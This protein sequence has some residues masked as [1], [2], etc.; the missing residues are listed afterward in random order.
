MI[1]L[2]WLRWW[3]HRRWIRF[4]IRDRL[5]RL[6][7][8]PEA[9]RK[10]TFS[11]DFFGYRYSGDLGS[12]VDWT[13]YFYGAY[14]LVVLELL[15]KAAA[16]AGPGAVYFDVGA[17]VGQHTLY[18]ANHV[19]RIHAFEPW[20]QVRDRLTGLVMENHLNQVTVHHFAL[21]DVEA[22]LPFF[23]P[24]TVNLGTG[25][26][27][28]G[29]NINRAGGEFLVRVGDEVVEEL[30][31]NRLDLV[32]IDTEGFEERVLVGLRGSLER[33]GP[34]VVVEIALS[35]SGIMDVGRLFP[36]GW[37]ILE[38]DSHPEKCRLSSCDPTGK[39]LITVLAGPPDK[40]NR[41][42]ASGCGAGSGRS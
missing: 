33:F 42:L 17:N 13:V 31:L 35:A 32:K 37:Q 4:G 24:T 41:L 3:G 25:S 2:R 1:P 15:A 23:V 40:V 28:S 22:E 9:L 11:C 10:R 18:M 7:A 20:P 27:C 30:K 12:F 26:F 6:L 36:D 8:P 5:L 34:L 14:E 38:L 21:G 16:L 39:S 19:A 29:V